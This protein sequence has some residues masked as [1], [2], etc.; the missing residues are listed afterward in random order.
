MFCDSR[1]HFV[2]IKQIQTILI[3]YASESSSKSSHQNVD[4]YVIILKSQT[5]LHTRRQPKQILETFRRP[6][7]PFNGRYYTPVKRGL[8]SVREYILKINDSALSQRIRAYGRCLRILHFKI[9]CSPTVA[10]K[11][12]HGFFATI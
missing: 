9:P 6:I 3:E 4:R 2:I 1:M 12:I 5:Y 8:V 7:L 11:R 10:F